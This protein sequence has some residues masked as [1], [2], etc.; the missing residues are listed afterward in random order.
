MDGAADMDG[1][2]DVSGRHIGVQWCV[3][4]GG[5]VVTVDGRCAINAV[6]QAPRVFFGPADC[7]FLGPEAFVVVAFEGEQLLKVRLTVELA[8]QRG[9]VAQLQPA[10]AE[11][12]LEAG[13]VVDDVVGHQL[14]R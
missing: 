1:S 14:F 6:A 12:A 3:D 11:G 10:F 8:L 13:N 5:S 2:V 7:Q 4:A 9:I